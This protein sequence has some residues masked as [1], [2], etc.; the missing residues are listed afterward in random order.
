MTARPLPNNCCL[1][2]KYLE[3][4]AQSRP[5]KFLPV[6]SYQAVIKQ[7]SGSHH[8]VRGVIDFVAIVLTYSKIFLKSNIRPQKL[9]P[10]SNNLCTKK[11]VV[12]KIF[13]KL[14]FFLKSG[15]LKSRFHCTIMPKKFFLELETSNFD[16]S[17]VFSSL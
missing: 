13:L 7:L 14:R 11:S 10:K 16:Y 17:H 6:F 15:F 4:N 1:V 2:K 8:F 9:F 3:S 12:P 5:I